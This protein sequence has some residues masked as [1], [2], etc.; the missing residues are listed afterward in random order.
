M[1]TAWPPARPRSSRA[2]ATQP[3]R[4]RRRRGRLGRGGL[5]AVL[6]RQRAEQGV[7]RIRRARRPHA[8]HRGSGTRTA[9]SRGR[10][11]GGARQPSVRRIRARVD[12]D[13]DQRARRRAGVARARDRAVT[14]ND[15]RGQLRR[16]HPQHHRRAVADQCRH[17]Q[18]G[19]GAAQRHHGLEPR[20]L[21]LRERQKP[22]RAG[23]FRQNSG[24]GATR[25]R[26]AW[27]KIAAS[28]A[29][30][31]ADAR[32]AGARTPSA[33]FICSMCAIPPSTKRAMCRARS[34][35]QAASWCRRRINMSARSAPASCSSTMPKCAR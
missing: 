10:R 14:G 35:R 21:C 33:R 5:R 18:Q 34:R 19:R 13:R 30:D 9:H 3:L 11:R 4:S 2:T 6:G 25:R 22:P 7:R 29:I 32:C 1:A 17:A 27:R 24:L 31:R 23:R 16:P 15:G 28:S 8:E 12:P 20:R 26:N